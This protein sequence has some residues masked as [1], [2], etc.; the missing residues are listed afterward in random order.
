MPNASSIS[1]NVMTLRYLAALLMVG[2]TTCAAY[3]VM[4]GMLHH[5]LSHHN[6]VQALG[7]QQGLTHRM[8]H[9]ADGFLHSEGPEEK[10]QA[11]LALLESLDEMEDT[12]GEMTGGADH[13]PSLKDPDLH[14]AYFHA[15]DGLHTLLVEYFEAV[16]ELID[17]EDTHDIDRSHPHAIHVLETLPIKIM[18]RIQHVMEVH[19]AESQERIDMALMLGGGLVGAALL[20]LCLA[21]LMVF[22]PMTGAIMKERTALAEANV[23]LERLATRDNL[24][25][26]FNRTK[27]DD[28]SKAEMARAQREGKPLGCIM[29]DVD[30]FKKFNDTYGHA[31]G[32]AVLKHVAALLETNTRATDYVFRWG[33]EE[34]LVLAPGNTLNDAYDTAEKLR[35]VIA[36][37]A[38]PDGHTV[39]ISVGVTTTDG[40]ESIDAVTHRADEALYESKEAGRNRVTMKPRTVNA[41]GA[42]AALG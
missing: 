31:V 8:L 19:D 20:V 10:A 14:D 3:L 32:D 12:H 34:F 18:E 17:M 30:H 36:G 22:R 35:A 4:Y 23:T 2:G 21:G 7:E 5:L 11:R 1:R 41:D 26:A 40:N 24:T 28:V 33:G 29:L 6:A 39:H 25:Q 42:V 27:F 13:L 38:T 37:T 15:E 16:R 9:Q